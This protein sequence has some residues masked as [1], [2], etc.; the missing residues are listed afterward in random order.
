MF[1]CSCHALRNAGLKNLTI[2]PN[3]VKLEGSG[4]AFS[5]APL[6]PTRFHTGSRCLRD[7]IELDKK[8]HFVQNVQNSSTLQSL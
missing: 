6:S 3:R 5:E 8:I 7:V 2:I 1:L 4:Q